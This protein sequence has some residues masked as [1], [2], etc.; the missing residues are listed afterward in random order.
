MEDECKMEG[1]R[2][3]FAT[4]AVSCTR[5]NGHNNPGIGRRSGRWG[6]SVSVGVGVL[7]L[8]EVGWGGVLVLVLVG[9]GTGTGVGGGVCALSSQVVFV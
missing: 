7:V 5:T 1:R 4:T 6:V 9:V 2:R 8:V 3:H